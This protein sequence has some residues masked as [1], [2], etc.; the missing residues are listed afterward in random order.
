MVIE[1]ALI[2][3]YILDFVQTKKYETM[4]LVSYLNKIE[5]KEIY[6]LKENNMFKNI[7]DMSKISTPLAIIFEDGSCTQC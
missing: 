6:S 5:K 1:I 3:N 4:D 2:F 7:T